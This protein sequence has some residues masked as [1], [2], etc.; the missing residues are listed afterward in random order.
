MKALFFVLM[1]LLAWQT[2]DAQPGRKGTGVRASID[3][4]GLTAKYF[5]NDGFAIEAQVN[6]GG[7]RAL[8]GRS[9]YTCVLMQYHIELPLPAFRL[10]FGGGLHGGVWTDR[11]EATYRDEAIFGLDGIGGIEYI[12]TSTP[13]GISG[14]LR[15]SIN[16]IQEVEFMPHNVIGVSVRYY[17]GSNKVKPF[18]YPWRIRRRFQ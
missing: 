18:E 13:I 5:L 14:D 7:I 6:V 2:V 1:A 12:F 3:G 15:P 16:Y 4:A 9:F 11:P 17:F 10:Y 8:D